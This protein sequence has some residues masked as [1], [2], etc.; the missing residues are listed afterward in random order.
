MPLG[1][2]L[3][4]I[5]FYA[6]GTAEPSGY[7]PAELVVY[8]FELAPLAPEAVE[9]LEPIQRER[10]LVFKLPNRDIDKVSKR[11]T[12]IG[13]VAGV[14]VDPEKGKF[15]SAHDLRRSF[16]FRWSRRTI[17]V[18]ELKELMRHAS[19]ET[20]LAYYVGGECRGDFTIALASRRQHSR[21]QWAYFGPNGR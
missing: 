5:L 15:A 10:G 4:R 16:G 1:A 21:Q 20:T 18:A 8:E 12:K 17:K 3:R 19:I 6:P 14:I 7:A 2:F 9:L 13:K 11:I